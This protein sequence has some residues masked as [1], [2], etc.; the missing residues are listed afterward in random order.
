MKENIIINLYN[1]KHI[2]IH[3]KKDSITT[4][5]FYITH[6]H[7]DLNTPLK[8]YISMCNNTR[9]AQYLNSFFL[10]YIHLYICIFQ[11]DKDNRQ[12]TSKTNKNI[13]LDILYLFYL[14]DIPSNI[15]INEYKMKYII[16]QNA[17]KKYNMDNIYNIYNTN[18][19]LLFVKI[20]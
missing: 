4:K 1:I 5:S 2:N 7:N 18:K 6:N 20:K 16:Q 19:L 10:Y 8:H 3:T 15:D 17:T 11:L 13:Y 14:Y 9:Y 12:Y